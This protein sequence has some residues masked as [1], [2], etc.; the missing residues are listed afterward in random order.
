MNGSIRKQLV[1]QSA[2]AAAA[3]VGLAPLALWPSPL[4]GAWAG[5][6]MGLVREL[7]EEGNISLA[8]LRHCFT[9]P[10]SRLDLLG[11]TIGGVIAG[12]IA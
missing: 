7:T 6:L 8:A 3:I 1:D 2:H 11:W 9:G 5:L 10:H 12:L 4:T